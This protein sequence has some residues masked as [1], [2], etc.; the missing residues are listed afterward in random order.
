MTG[1]SIAPLRQRVC[2]TARTF[3]KLKAFTQQ[4][5]PR[6]GLGLPSTGLHCRQRSALK[7]SAHHRP[8]PEIRKSS[9]PTPTLHAG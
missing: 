6:G 9:P 4:G 7:E 1:N 3:W 8:G 5:S 2:I